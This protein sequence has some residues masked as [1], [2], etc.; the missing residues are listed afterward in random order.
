MWPF[1]RRSQAAPQE[2][3]QSKPGRPA[4]QSTQQDRRADGTVLGDLIAKG[5]YKPSAGTEKFGYFDPANAPFRTFPNGKTGL[6]QGPMADLLIQTIPASRSVFGSMLDDNQDLSVTL[7]LKL[8]VSSTREVLDAF[9]ALVQKDETAK[10]LI[11][12]TTMPFFLN[13]STDKI[14]VIAEVEHELKLNALANL[15]LTDP[16][17]HDVASVARFERI[18][19]SLFA[20]RKDEVEQKKQWAVELQQSRSS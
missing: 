6:M 17:F 9:Q 1:K 14:V 18:A 4:T 19:E 8:G 7:A 20:N 3:S 10:Y 11:V 2:A 15:L 16:A 5:L 12:T 13:Y